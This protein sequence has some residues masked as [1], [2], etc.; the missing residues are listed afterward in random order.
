M[1]H[2]ATL[3]TIREFSYLLQPFPRFRG[4]P[5]EFRYDRSSASVL[6]RPL[7]IND[8]IPAKSTKFRQASLLLIF[9]PAISLISVNRGIVIIKADIDNEIYVR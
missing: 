2:D 5:R 8:A 9:L 3:E 1:T 7:K 4:F 6:A